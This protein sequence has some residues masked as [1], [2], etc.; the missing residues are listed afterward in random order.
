[1][2]LLSNDLVD[3]QPVLPPAADVASI[4]AIGRLATAASMGDSGSS[5]VRPPSH[6]SALDGIRAA[7]PDAIVTLVTDDDPAAAAAAANAADVAIV[8]TGLIAAE[9]GEYISPDMS[10]HP[11][12]GALRPPRSEDRTAR[13][14]TP[15]A[16][17]AGESNAAATVESGQGGDRSSLRLRPVDEVI[18]H[19]VAGSS[20]RTVVALVTAGAV[21]TE[22]RRRE[23]PATLIMRYA[24]M[25]GGHALADV[26]TGRHYPSGRLPYAIP[27]SEEHLPFFDRDATHIV[28]ERLHGQRLLDQMG[29]EPAY[30]HGFGLSYTT[31]AI[32]SATI[33]S[34]V[35]SGVHLRVTA[36]NAGD[37]DGRHVVQVDGQRHTGTDA[38]EHLLGGFAVADVPAGQSVDVA[39]DVSL[40]ALADLD[41]DS[42][43]RVAPSIGGI[44]LH[45][46]AH[47]HD[48]A[49][50]VIDRRDTNDNR[51]GGR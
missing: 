19:A 37:R 5:N 6:V 45:V 51:P 20:P 43:Q 11:E 47:A 18:I 8:I 50:I 9:E 17:Q 42:R 31:F 2:V 39:I 32:D 10:A 25:E 40:L 48:P 21:I 38:G 33:E 30:P 7:F 36:R 44:S 12:L 27:T 29:V 35:D 23:V 34:A 46:R 13:P 16:G 28:Y 22:S 4:A 26:L 14:A 24:G 15:A 1:M 49:S 3:G 41:P